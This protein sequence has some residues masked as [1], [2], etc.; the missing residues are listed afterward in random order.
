[1]RLGATI[2]PKH[3]EILKDLY[4]EIPVAPRYS[5]PLS[6][7]GFH[8][9]MKKQFEIALAHYKNDGTP[10]DFNVE[11]CKGKGCE[12]AIDELLDGQ[13]L[14]MCAKCKEVSYCCQKCQAIDWRQH[15]CVLMY[16]F[17]G[18]SFDLQDQHVSIS[19]ARPGIA[20]SHFLYHP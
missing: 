5:T 1:M 14:M 7:T 2:S 20:V 4:A 17:P 10:Y 18:I 9:P 16:L 15:V 12:K 8:E 19:L 3:M 6:D 13:K 11:R